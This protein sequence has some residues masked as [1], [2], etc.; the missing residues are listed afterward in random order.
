LRRAAFLPLPGVIHRNN[1]FTHDSKTNLSVRHYIEP[2][3]APVPG[4]M[5]NG[6][7]KQTIKQTRK[8]N[9]NENDV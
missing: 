2:D 5:K 9:E 4:N 8:T 3:L 1:E 7:A 6:T